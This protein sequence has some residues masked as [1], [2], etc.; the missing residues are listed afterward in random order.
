M[1]KKKI[2][3]PT[4]GKHFSNKQGQGRFLQRV[5]RHLFFEEY[6]H[7]NIEAEIFNF[8]FH[9]C[10]QKGWFRLHILCYLCHCLWI[11]Q[12]KKCLVEAQNTTFTGI[13]RYRFHNTYASRTENSGFMYSMCS[14]KVVNILRYKVLMLIGKNF[15]EIVPPAFFEQNTPLSFFAENAA[16]QHYFNC[17]ASFCRQ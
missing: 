4:G 8:R 10:T 16:Y 15:L 1:L 17:L 2:K 13:K 3:Y 7:N 6:L 5:P 11:L 9:D 14:V 12:T